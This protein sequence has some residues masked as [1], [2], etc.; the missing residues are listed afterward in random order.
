MADGSFSAET[1]AGAIEASN[2]VAATG[3]FQRPGIPD[4]VPAAYPAARAGPCNTVTHASSN[5]IYDATLG[6]PL[7]SARTH[8]ARAAA[9]RT[10]KR[11]SPARP[12]DAAAGPSR[13]L[14]LRRR[15]AGWIKTELKPAVA[16]G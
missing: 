1:L 15:E 2:V 7:A 10:A 11:P 13:H 8:P 12:A 4:L 6:F 3:P 14:L 16:A 9:E 5:A